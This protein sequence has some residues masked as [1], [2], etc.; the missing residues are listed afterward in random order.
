MALEVG[1]SD[2]E[3]V[4]VFV[5][6]WTVGEVIFGFSV[7]ESFEKEF[8]K[9]LP[10]KFSMV[11]LEFSEQRDRALKFYVTEKTEKVHRDRS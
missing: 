11:Y 1:L 6:A 9:L 2:S 10:I 7:T 5:E 3:T 8:N 4:R